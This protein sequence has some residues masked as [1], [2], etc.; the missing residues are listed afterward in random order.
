[1][2]HHFKVLRDAGLVA[3]RVDGQRRLYSVR[4]E[5]VRAISDWSMSYREFWQKS[6]DRLDALVSKE[7]PKR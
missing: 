4:P 3:Q 5:T 7:G 6:F 1:M 2:S